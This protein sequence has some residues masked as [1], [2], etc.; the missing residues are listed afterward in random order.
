MSEY[1]R[2]SDGIPRPVDLSMTPTPAPGNGIQVDRWTLSSSGTVGIGG[3]G[4]VSVG[5]GHIGEVVAF[6][7]MS[8]ANVAVS[9]NA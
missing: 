8:I 2:T 1:I 7:R 3:S 9:N 4:R 6:K 5:V